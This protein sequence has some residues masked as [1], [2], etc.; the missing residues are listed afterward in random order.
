MSRK[1]KTKAANLPENLGPPVPLADQPKTSIDE[2][3]RAIDDQIPVSIAPDGTVTIG[4]GVA[5]QAAEHPGSLP[6]DISEDALEPVEIE[7]KNERFDRAVAE[8]VATQ[9]AMARDSA[10]LSGTEAAARVA[11]LE[12]DTAHAAENGQVWVN[13]AN[14][15]AMKI[16]EMEMPK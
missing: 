8:A 6:T 4:D 7:I 10:W 2:I 5:L 11:L 15:I 12:T 13:C 3:E 14:H 16:A 9:I 1:K